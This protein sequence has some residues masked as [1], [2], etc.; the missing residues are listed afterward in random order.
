[1]AEKA[2]LKALL[3]E[4]WEK[5]FT[6]FFTL[7]G[8]AL[9]SLMVFCS[10][11]SVDG[12]Q[13]RD[14]GHTSRSTLDT[15]EAAIGFH[16]RDWWQPTKDNYFGSLKHTQIV[17]ALKEAGL[18]GAARD[19]EKMKKADAAGHAEHFMQHN[20]WVPAWLKGPLP[21]AEATADETTLD[22]DNTENNNDTTPAQAA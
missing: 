22:S 21:V 11:C 20:R 6:T 15:V 12:V 2:R 4:G 8:E 17:D 9:M 10:A 13:T 19:A 5:D 14:N 7:N 1:M 18:T 3:P 16:L